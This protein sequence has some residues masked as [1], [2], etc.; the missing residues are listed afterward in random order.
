MSLTEAVHTI[1]VEKGFRRPAPYS[2]AA[3]KALEESSWADVRTMAFFTEI[4]AANQNP[5]GPPRYCRRFCHEQP[6]GPC[7]CSLYR[8]A[9]R[10]I[11]RTL[12]AATKALFPTRRPRP[13]LG[14]PILHSLRLCQRSQ[15]DQ[16]G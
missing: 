13:R 5:K 10:R 16:I 8:E 6:Y 7:L 1:F 14:R 4:S 3:K 2:N 11:A 9:S 12:V 15:T